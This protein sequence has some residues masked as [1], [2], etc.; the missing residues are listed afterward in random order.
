VVLL[1]TDRAP[2]AAVRAIEQA[3]DCT[4]YDHYGTTEM[5]L[6]GGVDC[7]ARS[8][9]HLREAD[10]FFEI[11]HPGTG[12]PVAEGESGEVVFTTLTRAA[13]PLIRYRTGDVSRFIPGTCSCGTVLRR[14]AHVDERLSGSITLPGGRSLRQADLDEALFPLDGLA[15]FGVLFILEGGS[16]TLVVEVRP[17]HPEAPVHTNEVMRALRSIPALADTTATTP[18]TLAIEVRHRAPSA[19]G[20]VSSGTTKRRIERVGGPLG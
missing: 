8:G 13:M 6:G 7:R 4:V 10:L 3:W 16:A 12:Q 2:H 11:V 15:D 14:M 19:A 9:Y 1:S 5:G 20:A 18:G 17:T